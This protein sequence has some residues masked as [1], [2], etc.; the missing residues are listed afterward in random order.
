M[1]KENT[2][3][4]TTKPMAYDALLCAFNR[5]G[6]DLEEFKRL[7]LEEGRTARQLREHYSIRTKTCLELTHLITP[8]Y[9]RSL[10]NCN[11]KLTKYQVTK[12]LIERMRDGVK[13]A[14]LAKKYGIAPCTVSNI[15]AG[16]HWKHIWQGIKQKYNDEILSVRE[17]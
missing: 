3:E 1:K 13:Q 5:A 6:V 8:E 4:N 15:C 7:Y 12:M 14:D 10:K 2:V 16:R 17:A 9:T 11:R